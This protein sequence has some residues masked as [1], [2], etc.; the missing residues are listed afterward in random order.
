MSKISTYSA[1]S[2]RKQ[3][4]TNING[5]WKTANTINDGILSNTNIFKPF[6]IDGSIATTIINNTKNLKVRIETF[7]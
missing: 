7:N 5:I 1:E 4:N 6:K 2:G 3:Y